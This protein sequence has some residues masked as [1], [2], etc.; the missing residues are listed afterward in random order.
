MWISPSFQDTDYP[1]PHSLDAKIILFEDRV[2]GWKL[3][4]ANQMIN[5]NKERLSSSS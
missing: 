2:L 4:I 3:N 1:F 5:G